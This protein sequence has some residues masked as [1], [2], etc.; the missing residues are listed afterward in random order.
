MQV[1]WCCCCNLWLPFFLQVS[2]QETEGGR[3]QKR[4]VLRVVCCAGCCAEVAHKEVWWRNDCLISND[5]SVHCRFVLTEFA[6]LS[7][8]NASVNVPHLMP[9]YD[10][11]SVVNVIVKDW[12]TVRF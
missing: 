1:E 7:V 9:I 11:S 6:E 3:L 4:C 5:C 12:I 2:I 8:V 10:G